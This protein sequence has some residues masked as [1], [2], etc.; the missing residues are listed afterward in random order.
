MMQ[1]RRVFAWA[2]SIIS[3]RVS[4]VCRVCVHVPAVCRV[5]VRVP[6]VCRV[7]MRAPAVPSLAHC[8][9]QLPLYS[10][11][12]CCAVAFATRPLSALCI[13]Q[14][15]LPLCS[16]HSSSVC[17]ICHAVFSAFASRHVPLQLPVVVC[18]CCACVC[19]SQSSCIFCICQSPCACLL[20]L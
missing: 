15:S 11:V 4:A 17:C 10:P 13:R 16:R 6:A 19:I 14:L 3:L 7:C 8:T 1:F 12:A 9:R 2:S 18:V 20:H 5:C